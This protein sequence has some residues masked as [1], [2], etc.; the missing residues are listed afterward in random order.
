MALPLMERALAGAGVEVTTVTTDDDGPGRHMH[1]PLGQAMKAECATRYYFRKQSEFYKCSLPLWRWL[2]GHVRG[3]DL[4]HVHALFSFASVAAARCARGRRV[5]YVIRP[6]GLLNRYG[7]TQ[8]RRHLKRLSFRFIERALLQHAAAMHYTSTQ[9]QAEAEA[10]GATARAFVC[11]IGLD[12]GRSNKLPQPG[13]FLKRWPK[14]AGRDIVLFL[15]RLDPKK[16][17]DL[18]L[19]AFAELLRSHP[20]ALLVIAGDGDASFIRGVHHQA[21]QLGI[22]DDIIWTGFLEGQD[23]LSAFA[24]AR[25][26]ALPS[27]SENF[28]IAVVEA[29]AAGVP[30]LITREVGIA[31]QVQQADAGLVVPASGP[32]VASGLSRLLSEPGLAARFSANGREL[33]QREYSLDTMG[34]ALLGLYRQVISAREMVA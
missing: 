23:K 3:F 31:D 22:S 10:S 20:R 4:V 15:S 30:T 27:R 9:E 24:A 5:P 12:F 19:D 33:A 26:F 11:P 34:A 8:R 29:L 18:L 28:G 1:V 7:M 17:L 2:D 32:D 13:Q 14:S 6:L 16:G 21:D 25:V